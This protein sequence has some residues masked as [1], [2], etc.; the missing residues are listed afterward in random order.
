VARGFS[1]LWKGLGKKLCKKPGFLKC[2]I[3]R[4]EPVNI[5][6]GE[7]VVDQQDFSIP[8][9]IPIEWNRHYSS[10]SSRM[11]ICG[12]GWETPADARLEMDENGFIL[13]HDGTGTIT[14]FQTLPVDEPVMEPIDGGLL[15]RAEGYY[16]VQLKNGLIYYFPVP[17][18]NTK[19]IPVEYIMDLCKNYLRFIWDEN[20]L[21]EIQESAGRRIEVNSE[22]GM[23]LAMQLWHPDYERPHPLVR[24]KYSNEGDLALVFDALNNPYKFK[25]EKHCLVQ[26]T[27]RNGLSFYYEYDE[28]NNSGRCYRTW[29]DGDLYHYKFKY[30]EIEGR[31]EVTDSLGHVSSIYYNEHFQ[32]SREIDALGGVTS[33]EYDDVGRTVAVIDPDGNTTKYEYDKRGNL[34]KLI[35]PDGNI[36]ISEFNKLNKATKIIDPNNALWQ[37][38]WDERGLLIKQTSPSGAESVYEYDSYGQ[39]VGF[40][41]PNKAYTCLRYNVVGNLTCL[42]DANGNENC[43]EYDMLGNFITKCDSEGSFVRYAYDLNNRLIHVSLPND[44]FVSCAYDCEG[45]LVRYVDENGAETLL[46]YCGVGEVKRR[47]Q[48]DGYILEYEYDTEERLIGLINQRGEKSKFTRDA[49]G[50]IVEEVDFWGQKRSYSY[51]PHGNLTQSIDAMGRVVRYKLDPLGR[52]LSKAVYDISDPEKADY[53]YF[54]YDANGNL[55]FCENKNVIIE[56]FFDAEGRLTKERQGDHCLVENKYDPNGYRIRRTTFVRSGDEEH[57]QRTVYKYDLLGQL[58]ALEIDEGTSVEISRDSLGQIV[59]ESFGSDLTRKTQYNVDGCIINQRLYSERRQFAAQT[60]LYDKA[61]NLVE[62]HDSDFGVEKFEYDP[63]GRVTNYLNSAGRLISYYSDEVGDNYKT[64]VLDD[65]VNGDWKRE[66]EFNG[67]VYRFDRSGN[68]YNRSDNSGEV[69]FFWDGNQRLIESRINGANSIAYTYDPLGRRILKETNGATT[70]FLW[71]GDALLGDINETSDTIAGGKLAQLREWIYYPATHKPIAMLKSSAFGDTDCSSNTQIYYY[72][73]DPNGCPTRL[74]DSYGTVV[75]AVEYDIWGNI[76]KTHADTV[77]NPLRF[78]GQFHDEDIRLYY[79]RH[80]YYSPHSGQF[81]IPDL[82]G[83]LAGCNFYSYAPNAMVWI[84]PL[85]LS[86]SKTFFSVQSADDAARLARGG[87]PWPTGLQRANMGP[88]FYA[89]GSR[90]DAEEYLRRLQQQGAS[91]LRV[92]AYEIAE[93]DLAKLRT[94]DLTRLSDEAVDE[95]MDKYSHYGDA[96]P[97]DYQHIIRNTGM[98]APEHYFSPDAFKLFGPAS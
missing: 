21:K 59:L 55:T 27:D 49:L 69:E 96:L 14:F 15:R 56:R 51:T 5:V 88:G 3:F 4:A 70:F 76:V 8:G 23:V 22:N 86:C 47:I 1:R 98:G 42:I 72:H 26:H 40:I 92:A 46:D 11:G 93:G 28:Y 81:I 50:R 64:Q 52:M 80:R 24:Y 95:F 71:D 16:A 9:R 60:Y 89:W 36:I 34:V 84:D 45:N 67:Q 13:F 61:S 79:N 32:V 35:R 97:H 6:T 91:D 29:G 87:E 73:N 17:K 43:F 90:V 12:H 38:E 20:G 85:G 30:L 58:C 7:V 66:G 68:L 10:Q 77:S 39:L 44:V 82:L 2:K 48:P 53:E 25:Y 41:N 62:K 83:L 65:G 63:L 78:Q 74:I 18:H 33:Y 31:T 37:Q 94:K 54:K 75:W 19:E 57:I